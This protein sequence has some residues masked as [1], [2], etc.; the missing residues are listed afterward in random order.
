[1]VNLFLLLLAFFIVLVALS[2]IVEERSHKAIDSIAEV[3]S[4][5]VDATENAKDT[6][7]HRSSGV[8]DDFILKIIRTLIESEIKALVPTLIE[9]SANKLFVRY[10]LVDLFSSNSTTIRPDKLIV[11]RRIAN[12]IVQSKTPLY[13][14]VTVTASI[15]DF[16]SSFTVGTP[17]A[18]ERS[19]HLVDLLQQEGV[20][21][22][23]LQAN[24]SND[25][26]NYVEFTFFS[27]DNSFPNI[28]IIPKGYVK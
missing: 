28:Q 26:E 9:R 8:S 12:S 3:F 5:T 7:Q 21:D 17:Q 13:T 18:A 25:N 1:M 24:V 4:V 15:A 14:I 2:E 20:T 16:T 22:H 23:Y 11:I 10:S 6:P 19:T 27:D